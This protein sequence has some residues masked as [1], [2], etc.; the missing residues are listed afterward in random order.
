QRRPRGTRQ[1]VP[2]AR[3]D[4]DRPPGLARRARLTAEARRLARGRPAGRR[5]RRRPFHAGR[6]ARPVAFGARGPAGRARLA[7]AALL[8]RAAAAGRA[9]PEA[10]APAEGDRVAHHAA[11][12]D[13]LVGHEIAGREGGRRR[14]ALDALVATEVADVAQPVLVPAL[15]HRVQERGG[16][17][18]LHLAQPAAQLAGPGLGLAAQDRL[19]GAADGAG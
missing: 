6:L 8:G 17:R 11:R 5:K 1:V 3:L 15:D 9:T 18:A 19:A 12:P 16:R 7:V 14:A 4:L 13:H 2:G 10:A